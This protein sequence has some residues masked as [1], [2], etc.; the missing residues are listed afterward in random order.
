[1]SDEKAAQAGEGKEDITFISP[2]KKTNSFNTSSNILCF[3]IYENA[4]FAALNGKVSIYDLSG[5]KLSTQTFTTCQVDLSFLK[6]GLYI[7]HVQSG[8]ALQVSKLIKK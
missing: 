6:P 7:I 1:M 8:G 5:R 4:I 3:D 2:Y